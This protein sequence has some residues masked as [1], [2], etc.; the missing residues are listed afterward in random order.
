MPVSGAKTSLTL[1]T[2]YAFSRLDEI[3]APG[4]PEWTQL[5]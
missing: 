3:A 1:A 2:G 4:V 5:A